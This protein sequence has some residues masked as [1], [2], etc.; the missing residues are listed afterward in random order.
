MAAGA[1]VAAVALAVVL[2]SSGDSRGP[3]EDPPGGG[4]AGPGAGNQPIYAIGRTVTPRTSRT[5]IHARPLPFLRLGCGDPSADSVRIVPGET[6]RLCLPFAAT[7]PELETFLYAPETGLPDRR[8]APE[9][10]GWAFG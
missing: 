1:V 4:D 7:P 10:A 2:I 9:A 3:L 5:T 8:G 6:Q